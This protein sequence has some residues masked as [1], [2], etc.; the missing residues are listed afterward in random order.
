[1]AAQGRAEAQGILL[2]GQAAGPPSTKVR[3]TNNYLGFQKVGL[4]K[5]CCIVRLC[6]P[7]A[8]C[9]AHRSGGRLE[10]FKQV[11]LGAPTSGTMLVFA[12]PPY[13]SVCS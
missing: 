1:M 10:P 13:L 9:F 2:G 12:T 6:L 4:P 8:N 11:V 5:L 3:V 7:Y